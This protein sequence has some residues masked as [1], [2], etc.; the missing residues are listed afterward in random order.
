MSS[1]A[2]TIFSILVFYTS[3]AIAA[4]RARPPHPSR[5]DAMILGLLQT[6][7][8]STGLHRL[9]LVRRKSHWA[10]INLVFLSNDTAEKH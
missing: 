1:A 5:H 9:G 4:T 6:A 2:S 10:T 7:T 8:N 3:Y